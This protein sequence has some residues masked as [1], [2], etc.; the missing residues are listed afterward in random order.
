M[1]SDG[2]LIYVT[3]QDSNDLLVF[4]AATLEIVRSYRILDGP[5]GIAVAG[6]PVDRP[7]PP[8]DAARA[9]FNGSSSR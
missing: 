3:N 4:D 7:V 2:R 1:S 9:D 6:Q 8:G 5:R